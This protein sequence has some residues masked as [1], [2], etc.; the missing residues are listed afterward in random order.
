VND[1]TLGQVV[2]ELVDP[3]NVGDDVPY[4]RIEVLA[5]EEGV[6]RVDQALAAL[7]WFL[8]ADPNNLTLLRTGVSM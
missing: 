2:F 1:G 5:M 7:S 4:D 6:E 3:A 8:A